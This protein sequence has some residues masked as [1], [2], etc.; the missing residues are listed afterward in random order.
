MSNDQL[1]LSKW[2]EEYERMHGKIL[3]VQRVANND[4]RR[5]SYRKYSNPSR[6]EHYAW[7]KAQSDALWED[8]RKERDIAHRAYGPRFEALW[9][10]RNACIAKDKAALKDQYRPQW[11]HLY[12]DQR[13]ALAAYDNRFSERLK[14]A[15]YRLP[16]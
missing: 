15:C 5:T 14:Y 4:N 2:A 3:C 7:R 1:K 13:A 11:R 12:A 8:Y 16:S 6:R 10:K 9:N